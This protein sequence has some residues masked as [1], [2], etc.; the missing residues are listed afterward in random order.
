MTRSSEQP[1]SAA[2]A[3]AGLK[4]FQR[5]TV[6]YAF[7]RLY[8]DSDSTHRFLVADEVGLGKT[9]VARGV[10]AKAVEHL[11]NEV[12]RIDVVYVCS[13]AEIARQNIN[14]LQ[15]DERHDF[16]R[17][18]RA[19]LLPIELHDMA[20]R[21]VNYVSMTPG[22]SL[23]PQGGM[24]IAKER[25][26]LFAMLRSH[27]K[28]Q[29]KDGLRVLRGGVKQ[30]NFKWWTT[31]W[32]KEKTVDEGLL[33]G[34]LTEL[35]RLEAASSSRGTPSLRTRFVALAE[36]LPDRDR[37][38]SDTLWN[39]RRKVIAELRA[40]LG[41][42]CIT[43]L[44]PDLVIL[45]EFQRFK[46]LLDP[47]SED[48]ELARSLFEYA[49]KRE[50]SH[51]AV[52]VLLLSATP[53]KMYSL[54]HEQ[55]SGE[56]DHYEDFVATYDFLVG[57]QPD[58]N[59]AL[60]KLLR[61]YRAAMFNL[62]GGG[63]ADLRG[64]KHEIESR[65]RKV[66]ARTERLAVTSDRSG[67]LREIPSSSTLEPS[68]VR[69]YLSSSKVAA[70]LDHGEIVEYWKSAP[71]LLNFMDEYEL[72]KS[73]NAASE[74]G[75]SADL[76]QALS[77]P[78]A[79]LLRWDDVL[80]YRKID[81]ANA[82]LRSLL[83]DTVEKDVWKMLW[84]P[85]SMPYYSL[86]GA[87]AES[88]P[89]E[90]TKRLVF[91]SWKV[92]P[93][94]IAAVL[95]HEAERRMIGLSHTTGDG[96]TIMNSTDGRKRIAALLRFTRGD[97]RLTGMPVLGLIYPS[98][99]LAGVFDPA[100]ESEGTSAIGDVLAR[101]RESLREMT[102]RAVARWA[103]PGEVDERWYWAGPILL[104]YMMSVGDTRAFWHHPKLAAEW[105][106][107]EDRT[108][109]D[110]E[111]E[112]ESAWAEHIASAKQLLAEAGRTNVRPLGA[113]P[114]DLLDVLAQLT[115]GNP[116]VL[117]LRAFG[118]VLG[119]ETATDV[120]VRL[121]AGRI[122]W[123][124]RNL[125]NL[126]EV[127][128]LVRGLNRGEPYWL[129]VIE[130]A[131][132]GCL[133]AVLDEYMHV[134][135]DSLGVRRKSVAEAARAVAEEM[136]RAIGLRSATVGVDDI[137]ANHRTKS[138]DVNTERMR[139]RFA[140]R[141]GQQQHENG[142]DESRADQVRAAFNSPFWP[143]VLASTSVGQEG[144]DFHHYC[145][146]IVHWNLPSNPV[147]LEQREGRIHRYKGHAVRKNVAKA[148]GALGEL[149]ATDRWEAAFA[150]ATAEHASETSELKPFWVFPADGGA[151]IERHVPTLPLSRDAERL[152]NLRAALALYRMV[153]GQPRQDEL[154]KFLQ[155]RLTESALAQVVS[156]LK[157]DLEP[158]SVA[159]RS[160]AKPNS[161][162]AG[163]ELVH[164]EVA[165]EECDLLAVA[166]DVVLGH[167]DVL[168]LGCWDDRLW[169]FVPSCWP[170][171]LPPLCRGKGCEPSWWLAIWI[172][173]FRETECAISLMIAPMTDQPLRMRVVERLTQD[174]NEFG[175]R[176]GDFINSP[177]SP[178]QW[179][180]LAW[181]SLGLLKG[182]GLSRD[183]AR[184]RLR[185][186]IDAFVVR[187]G[188]VGDAI[189]PLLGQWRADG[190]I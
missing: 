15:I 151:V 91:S 108:D 161:E 136:V 118:H 113:P 4:D 153:F 98:I 43:A 34:F 144:L 79:G 89:M 51:E 162:E 160:V 99:A 133:Q 101:V 185:A 9:M 49:D 21:H 104:D 92:V 134:L 129:R 125:F 157:V 155:S 44:R 29:E 52:R 65:L 100:R 187:F 88:R 50:S 96:V 12:E 103:S 58:D 163:Q 1:P 132:D 7:R 121:A 27:W 69:Q 18:S 178:T 37:E 70:V 110:G 150:A 190:R 119:P 73:F 39:E 143:F 182:H 71:Y 117:A 127:I 75:A 45:D 36:S 172:D 114:A 2:A 170:E 14:R 167:S 31:E 168:P 35:D 116:A 97:G 148:Y 111:A 30:D 137:R 122:A 78:E 105:S 23:E 59:Q 11:W 10:I 135:R 180:F 83:Q 159:G 81:P 38:I 54:Q 56:N 141:F 142:K 6:E 60:R 156:E 139:A 90:L 48:A 42:T 102:D 138:V 41:R 82:R 64:I 145:H 184:E 93:K 67:M 20:K 186:A 68:D 74:S 61:D 175:I 16:A 130:Y 181:Q 47:T 164:E 166:K 131:I 63:L 57:H 95:S 66:M 171:K 28:V 109:A 46:H 13:N 84:L 154:V 149:Q 77:Q 165:S 112:A 80:A 173:K 94:V 24:G 183:E 85:S 123:R 55:E 19:T 40:I 8:Q 188:A 87:F 3:L 158:P 33:A 53:Y 140:A 126:P 26:V 22:T 152:T 174:P 76:Y 72:K 62:E 120:D 25:A 177:G 107:E 169:P 5:R 17:A 124:V 86:G 128:A 115:L 189:G 176:A 32:M 179:V 106:G 147:D 146:A